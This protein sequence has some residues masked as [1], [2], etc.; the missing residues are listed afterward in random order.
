MLPV[1]GSAASTGLPLETPGNPHELGCAQLQ[2][3]LASAQDSSKGLRW[4]I[5]KRRSYP[6]TLNTFLKNISYSI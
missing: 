6:I 2:K 4:I 3:H 1:V 5:L